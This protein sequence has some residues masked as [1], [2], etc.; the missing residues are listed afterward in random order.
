MGPKENQYYRSLSLIF[1]EPI[2]PNIIICAGNQSSLHGSTDIQGGDLLLGP[3]LAHVL[4]A[5]HPDLVV[6][7]GPQDG[8]KRVQHVLQLRQPQ[9]ALATATG[10]QVLLELD[11]ALVDQLVLGDQMVVL[12]ERG[13]ALRERREEILL[14]DRV[15]HRQRPAQLQPL[16]HKRPQRHPIRPRPCRA[17][18]V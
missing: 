15:V 6:E 9:L 18:L 2:Q 17:R 1:S 3:K 10:A 16:V 4:G 8:A 12:G 14:L 5:Q 13:H 11:D 7:M